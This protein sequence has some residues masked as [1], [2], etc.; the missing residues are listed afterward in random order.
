MN[1]L[2]LIDEVFQSVRLKM[3]T[4]ESMRFADL[5]EIIRK[6]GLNQKEVEDIQN[7]LKKYFIEIDEQQLIKLRSWAYDLFDLSK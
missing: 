3:E 4:T 6:Q 5:T 7:F 1:R 2:T